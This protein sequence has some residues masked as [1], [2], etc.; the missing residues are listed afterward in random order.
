MTTVSTI[1]KYG[2][3]YYL[4]KKYKFSKEDIEDNTVIGLDP[5]IRTMLTGYSNKNILEIGNNVNSTIKNK[6]KV[7]DLIT[8]KK[9][10]K[11]KERL[12]IKKKYRRI[13]NMVKD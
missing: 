3:E 2:N 11:T 7:I 8:E 12:I 13:K 6:L 5:G 1:K 4:L 10:N 9:F